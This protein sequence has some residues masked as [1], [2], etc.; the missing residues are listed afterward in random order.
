MYT[1]V[2]IAAAAL[3]IV[4]V[5]NLRPRR[6][7]KTAPADGAPVAAISAQPWNHALAFISGGKLFYQTP[8]QELRELQS[9]Y[10]QSVMDRMERSRQLHAWK[11]GTS[12]AM[13]FAGRGRGGDASSQALQIQTISA[14][15][16]GDGRVLYFLKDDSFGG[17]FEYTIADGTEKRLVHKQN[18]SLED[19]RL[20]PDGKQLLCAARARNG[21]ANVAMMNADGS[22]YRELSGGDTVD[23]CP[24]WVPDQPHLVMYQSSGLARNPGGFVIA[25]GPA[26]IQMADTRKGTLTPVMENPELDFLQPRLGP[27]GS[28]YYIRRPYEGHRYPVRNIVL[29]T[30]LFPYRLL[31]ALFHYLNFFSL[32]YTRKPLTTASGPALEADIKDILL[33]GKRFDAEQAIRSGNKLGGVPSLVPASW[34]LVRRNQKAEEQILASHVASFDLAPDGAILFSNGYGVF[35][36]EDGGKPRVLLKEKLIGDVIAGAKH[37]EHPAADVV[38]TETP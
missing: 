38:A 31:R 28:L 26:S 36:L 19:L 11:E 10:V 5:L 13:N 33:K 15:F 6:G 30:L 21:T 16:T 23:T 34:Q 35:A 37:A 3:A 32:M 20:S 17:L 27:D 7:S 18:L 29:D 25:T 1:T 4:A 22:D 12:L 14:Q 2:L 9:P 24:A 8:G